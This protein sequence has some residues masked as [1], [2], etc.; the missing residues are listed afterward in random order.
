MTRRRYVQINGELVEV[1]P[2]WREEPRADHHV[3]PDIKP[4]RSMIDGREIS[5]R[6][7]HREH[8]KAH[9]CIEVGNETAY[10]VNRIRPMESPSGLRERIS[11]VA[12]D[13]L[14]RK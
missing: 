5:S 3:M 13:K 1:S 4:Y 8:L 2:D 11:D 7:T 6:S 10:M 9:R 14:R 12:A